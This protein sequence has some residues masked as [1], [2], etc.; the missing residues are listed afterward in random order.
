MDP[1]LPVTKEDTNPAEW[2][3]LDLNYPATRFPN[4]YFP[5]SRDSFHPS[6]TPAANPKPEI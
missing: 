6:Q 2:Q 1:I 5:P 4:G 3:G